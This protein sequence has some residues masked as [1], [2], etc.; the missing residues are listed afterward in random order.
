MRGTGGK[1]SLRM[2]RCYI[3][4]GEWTDEC[5]H[6][7][8]EEARHIVCVLRMVCGAEVEVFDGQ[9][10][11]AVAVVRKARGEDVRLETLRERREAHPE[12]RF[13]L[14][15]A[16]PKGRV[17]DVVVEKATELGVSEIWPAVTERT[18]TRDLRN[19]R[20]RLSRWRRISVSAAKQC[21][22]AW[23]PDIAP[24]AHLPD[25]IARCVRFDWWMSGDIDPRT[26]L[27]REVL[28]RNPCENPHVVGLVI[29][30]EGDLTP[31]EKAD[32][33]SAGAVR[34]RFPTPVLR[35]DTA[36]LHGLSVLL[37]A[38]GSGSCEGYRRWCSEAANAALPRNGF[39]D[40]A[41]HRECP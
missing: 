22:R 7:P 9:G 20:A 29:G 38:F 11:M 28:F 21:G 2:H 35:V 1:A 34:A 13:V 4:P 3:P 10:R 18:E 36:A 37:H 14:I 33:A 15:Q 8:R 41:R 24:P 39:R 19:V 17:M 31:A 32:L 40:G 26:P 16:L 12:P 30:P 5:L 27:L 23:L 25:I 6:V